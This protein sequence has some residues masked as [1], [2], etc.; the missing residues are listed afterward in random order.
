MSPIVQILMGVLVV[1]ME[2]VPPAYNIVLILKTMNVNAPMKD[3]P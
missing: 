2:F 1:Q 3:S